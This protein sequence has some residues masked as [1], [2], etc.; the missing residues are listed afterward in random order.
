MRNYVSP[1]I[2][3]IE[4]FD[5]DG[6]KE[7]IL[8]TCKTV[9]VSEMSSKDYKPKSE[10]VTAWYGVLLY[11]K[12]RKNQFKY[13]QRNKQGCTI[14]IDNY[15]RFVVM[16]Q[17]DST[18]T[19]VMFV[20]GS[21]LSTNFFI[22]KNNWIGSGVI[23][24]D[25]NITGIWNDNAVITTKHPFIPFNSQSNLNLLPKTDNL[26]HSFRFNESCYQGFCFENLEIPDITE[27]NLIS[28]CPNTFC[29][30]NHGLSESCPAVVGSRCM[31]VNCI[32][33]VLTL[34]SAGGGVKIPF[35]SMDFT[36]KLIDSKI[37]MNPNR[38]ISTTFLR[39][40]LQLQLRVIQRHRL[41][42]FV[43]G[44]YR[45]KKSD[46]GLQSFVSKFHISKINCNADTE[47][48]RIPV[49]C[50]DIRQEYYFPNIYQNRILIPKQREI[51][52][53]GREQIDGERSTNTDVGEL[54]LGES[55]ILN[56]VIDE[57]LEIESSVFENRNERGIDKQHQSCQ[58]R[59]H[60]IQS[61]FDSI[62][63]SVAKEWEKRIEER[64]RIIGLN[65]LA[66]KSFKKSW[67]NTLM[68][69]DVSSVEQDTLGGSK[70]SAKMSSTEKRNKVPKSRTVFTTKSGKKS[71]KSRVEYYD[72]SQTHITDYMKPSTSTG[73]TENQVWEPMVIFSDSD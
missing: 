37:V 43:I 9:S 8:E 45:V 57:T 49:R 66:N 51:V 47:A 52:D 26:P 34:P 23:L 4:R 24:L 30:S 63:D 35:M 64:N 25:P 12:K 73:Q 32:E 18:N 56:D 59:N 71:K 5:V 13:T 28:A 29:D 40:C 36:S 68:E 17:I 33:G 44:W 53:N 3:A 42:W 72:E 21:T 50:S 22:Q 55:D 7:T 60:Q 10:K 14:P 16:Q 6:V 69:E 41:K 70:Q 1:W 19:V 54:D 65:Q 46:D 27:V 20:P 48:I 38:N 39:K 58:V 61:E 15:A 31:K 2:S 11:I 67:V 62:T